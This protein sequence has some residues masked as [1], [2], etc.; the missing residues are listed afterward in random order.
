LDESREKKTAKVITDVKIQD[1]KFYYKING[2]GF[3]DYNDE[4][5]VNQFINYACSDDGHNIG[6]S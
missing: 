3:T 4:F 5:S 1:G 2:P 6:I